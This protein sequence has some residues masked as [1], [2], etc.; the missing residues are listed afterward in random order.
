MS[1]RASMHWLELGG[2]QLRQSSGFLRFYEAAGIAHMRH[3]PI[4]FR[5]RSEPA[6]RLI[7]L[8]IVWHVCPII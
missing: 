7:C 6:W 8:P 2:I 5:F 3:H 1:V 4:A